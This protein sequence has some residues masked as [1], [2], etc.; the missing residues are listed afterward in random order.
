MTE[1]CP[2]NRLAPIQLQCHA[3]QAAWIDPRIGDDIELVLSGGGA[4]DASG[5]LLRGGW[6]GGAAPDKHGDEGAGGG[7]AAHGD[8]ED[9]EP[10]RHSLSA[11]R[12]RVSGARSREQRRKGREGRCSQ[13]GCCCCGCEE[14]CMQRTSVSSRS[15]STAPR[16]WHVWLTVWMLQRRPFQQGSHEHS[17]LRKERGKT[18][19]RSATSRLRVAEA[20]GGRGSS[21]KMEQLGPRTDPRPR[22]RSCRSPRTQAAPRRT[23]RAAGGA[24]LQAPPPPSPAPQTAPNIGPS[25]FF[26]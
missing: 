14:P 12:R 19:A 1:G 11:S 2:Q 23:G 15:L 22:R 3:A 4:A 9:D 6:L 17:Y 18:R 8:E 10:E 5:V 24:C 16:L 7:E 20:P 25:I 26:T 21:G 13:L